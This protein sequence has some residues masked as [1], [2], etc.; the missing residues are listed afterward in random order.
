MKHKKRSLDLPDISIGVEPVPIPNRNDRPRAR[1]QTSGEV[2]SRQASTIS[3]QWQTQSYA[4]L[5]V[6]PPSINN[7]STFNDV[8]VEDGR[9]SPNSYQ[10]QVV[11]STLPIPLAVLEIDTTPDPSNDVIETPI[12]W[13]GTGE[14]VLISHTVDDADVQVPLKRDGERWI[15]KLP[16]TRGTHHLLFVVDGAFRVANDM[17]KTVNSQGTLTN[18]VSVGLSSLPPAA[19]DGAPPSTP[20]PRS[21]SFW[22][23]SSA[24][25]TSSTPAALVQASEWTNVIPGELSEA[26]AEEEAFITAFNAST[27]I[28]NSRK[29][30]VNGFKPMPP[31][32]DH[33]PAPTLPRH[34]EK[35][36][37]N[38]GASSSSASNK[39]KRR[40]RNSHG[41]GHGHRLDPVSPPLHD[42][43]AQTPRI[44]PVTT[45]SGTDLS[46]FG[47]VGGLTAAAPALIL[48]SEGG[49]RSL[50]AVD[51]DAVVG[52]DGSVL[53]VPSH[54]VLNH[55]ST[56]S[57]RNGV[58]AVAN[59][60]R[61][62]NKFMT[63]IYY[64]PT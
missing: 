27:P 14:T 10:R 1:R 17:P 47:G 50:P 29:Q 15:V 56:S 48:S 43:N 38:S 5:Q 37:L 25:A 13:N 30:V 21:H 11:R 32:P 64:K 49:T 35:Q 41:H 26:A 3:T 57:I 62:K 12:V 28:N 33:P 46:S 61:Y 4:Q 9:R 8:G 40:G 20:I 16:L 18:Y 2:W 39:E 42:R 23:S 6:P 59:T 19:P 63:T 44:L 31:S 51:D 54:V 24:G 34:L 36:I 58:L 52:D 60:V 55:L 45:A 7:N 22:S 53:P